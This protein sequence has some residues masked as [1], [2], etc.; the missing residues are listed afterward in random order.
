MDNRTHITGRNL[1]FS[2]TITLDIRALKNDKY[3][4]ANISA[5]STQKQTGT[6][7]R[8]KTNKQTKN[9]ASTSCSSC[10]MA[11]LA[12]RTTWEQGHTDAC[13]VQSSLQCCTGDLEQGYPCLRMVGIS[14]YY[15]VTSHQIIYFS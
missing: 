7:I 12:N 6:C 11:T 10:L 1:T 14:S 4:Q 15:V 9:N 2:T 3:Y 8:K 13:L 5:G